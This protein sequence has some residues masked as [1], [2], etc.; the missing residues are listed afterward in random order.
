MSKKW[1]AKQFKLGPRSFVLYSR[2]LKLAAPQ[3]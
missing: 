2:G 1:L 3:Q